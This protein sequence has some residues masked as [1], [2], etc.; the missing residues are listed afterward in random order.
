MTPC[1]MRVRSAFCTVTGLAE[2][3]ATSAR[4]WASSCL[5]GAGVTV[6]IAATTLDE[7]MACDNTGTPSEPPPEPK[8]LL[9]NCMPQQIRSG[10]GRIP[11]PLWTP[12]AWADLPGRPW[13]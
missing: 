12:N 1:D 10:N 13:G 2:C 3:W 5:T 11:N 8:I 9:V 4:T 6:S 7:V